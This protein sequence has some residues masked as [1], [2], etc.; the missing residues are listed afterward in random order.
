M[1]YPSTIVYYT[2]S[3]TLVMDAGYIKYVLPMLPSLGKKPSN[4]LLTST[5]PRRTSPSY[6]IIIDQA[7]KSD[8]QE[9]QWCWMGSR[10]TT[11]L[12]S[13]DVKA[14]SFH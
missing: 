7:T 11:S 1:S 14:R 12:H 5:R 6:E 3:N 10:E 2:H 9:Q 4:W 13:I 8:S